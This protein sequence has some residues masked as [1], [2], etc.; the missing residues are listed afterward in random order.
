MQPASKCIRVEKVFPLEEGEHR[1]VRF[2]PLVCRSCAATHGGELPPPGLALLFRRLWHGG[3]ASFGAAA[4]G[5][6]GVFLTPKLLS[7]A[8]TSGWGALLAMGALAFFYGLSAACFAA[9]MRQ[10]RHLA[11]PPPTSISKCVDFTDDMSSTFEPSWYRFTFENGAYAERFRN[12]NAGL[13]WSKRNEKAKK[14]AARRS[15]FTICAWIAIACVVVYAI[16]DDTHE[17]FERVLRSLR[18]IN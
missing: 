10:T 9:A 17:W 11:C 8:F 15:M 18:V 2:H 4:N 14:A 7:T 6:F 5:A 13:I 16:Y 12:L 1:I 3:G